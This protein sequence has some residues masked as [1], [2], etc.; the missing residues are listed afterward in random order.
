M[1]LRCPRLSS[2]VIFDLSPYTSN[3]GEPAPHPA[4]HLCPG[5]ISN[6][7]RSLITSRW[8]LPMPSLGLPRHICSVCPQSVPR[9][10]VNS[11]YVSPKTSLE[12]AD[13]REAC[14]LPHDG[15]RKASTSRAGI[16]EMVETQMGSSP[17]GSASLQVSDSL[18]LRSQSNGL[19]H[20][21]ELRFPHGC[22][23]LED[24]TSQ[25]HKHSACLPPQQLPREL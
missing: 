24:V 3:V 9:G 10:C 20:R 22:V 11:D 17:E 5:D 8:N 23:Y 1:P 12:N 13:H 6:H 4:A 14:H 15:H 25:K 16:L 2:H 18:Q 21:E 7:W 19:S